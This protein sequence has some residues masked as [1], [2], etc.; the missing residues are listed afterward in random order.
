MNIKKHIAV[1]LAISICLLSGCGGKKAETV[2]AA[3][4]SVT[5]DTTQALETTAPEL[6]QDE[7]MDLLSFADQTPEE[8]PETVPAASEAAK[9]TVPA[10]TEAIQETDP[11]SLETI[12]EATVPMITTPDGE[13]IPLY[14]GNEDQLPLG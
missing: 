9:E 11:A 6:P 14:S 2:P 5:A 3:T 4:E 7:K 13:T 10:V 12:P 8:E 1:L